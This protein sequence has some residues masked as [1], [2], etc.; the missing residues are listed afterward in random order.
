MRGI[1]GELPTDQD[2]SERNRGL[3]MR[4]GA[5]RKDKRKRQEGS[6]RQGKLGRKV[7]LTGRNRQKDA[8]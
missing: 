4:Q 8:G 3:E 7:H 5:D 1:C 6:R 2:V